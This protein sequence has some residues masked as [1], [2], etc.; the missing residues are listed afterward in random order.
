MACV[1]T[2]DRTVLP[3]TNAMTHPAFDPQPQR[4]TALWS[5]FI[6][7]PQRIGG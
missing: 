6:P 5:V 1:L 2:R 4:I 7:V 3:A